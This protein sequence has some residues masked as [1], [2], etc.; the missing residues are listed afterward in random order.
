M[1]PEREFWPELTFPPINLWNVWP[2]EE[3]LALDMELRTKRDT[4]LFEQDE[5]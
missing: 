5:T 2:S 1:S 4:D 3:M